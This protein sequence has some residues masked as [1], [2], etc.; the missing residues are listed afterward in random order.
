MSVVLAAIT[1]G[2][3]IGAADQYLCLLLV[4]S[5]SRFGWITLSPQMHFMQ[6]WWFLAIVMVFWLLTVAPAYLAAVAP[7]VMNTVNTLVNFL[8]GFVVPFSAALVALA[9]FGIISDLNPELGQVLET[10]RLFGPQGTIAAPGL[11]VAGMSGLMAGSLTGAKAVA[12]PAISAASGT[13]GS[14]SAPIFATAEN[15]S[16]LLALG[17]IYGLASIHPWL[18]VLLG[19]VVVLLFVVVFILA[20][21]QLRNLKSS[22]GVLINLFRRSPRAALAVLLEFLVWGSGSLLRG[23]VKRGSGMLTFWLLYGLGWWATFA[24]ASLLPVIHLVF[25]P[26]SIVFFLMIGLA[27]ASRLLRKLDRETPP[28]AAVAASA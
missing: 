8:S 4:G 12:K 10:L 19:V 22:G 17:L 2:G 14:Y 6:S 5:A 13:L 24:V 15:G 23:E 7:G 25:L 21:R 27:T 18:V 26:T 11:A 3:L 9:S 28:V 16:S 1:S 20:L